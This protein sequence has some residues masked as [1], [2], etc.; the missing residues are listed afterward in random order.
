MPGFRGEGRGVDKA[1]E[2]EEELRKSPKRPSEEVQ[3]Q[4][5]T[6]NAKK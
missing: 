2:E 1:E 4:D 6:G 5:S 3:G